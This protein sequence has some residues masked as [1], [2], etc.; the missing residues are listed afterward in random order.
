MGRVICFLIAIL[1]NYHFIHNFPRIDRY[2]FVF[3]FLLIKIQ[4]L[5]SKDMKRDQVTTKTFHCC[6]NEKQKIINNIV[7]N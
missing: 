7:S 4:L 6:V 5:R 1:E 3:H 2:I